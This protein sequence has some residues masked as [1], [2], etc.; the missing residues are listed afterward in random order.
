MYD[1]LNKNNK[2]K[3]YRFFSVK[4]RKNFTG[5]DD[6]PLLTEEL[7]TLL[8][9]PPTNPPMK[10]PKIQL[11]IANPTCK[12]EEGLK[13]KNEPFSMHKIVQNHAKLSDTQKHA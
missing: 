3:K 1:F 8:G 12:S 4:V 13:R 9:P 2:T 11:R 7:P 6:V 10:N 5:W